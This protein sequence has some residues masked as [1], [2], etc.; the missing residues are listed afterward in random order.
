MAKK[1]ITLTIFL[2]VTRVCFGQTQLE[3][4][5][6]AY[7]DYLNA[8]ALMTK[9]YRKAQKVLA[10]SKQKKLLLDAQRAWLIFKESHCK[11]VAEA[12]DKGSMQ[13]MVYSTCLQQ[14][15]KERTKQLKR[16][17]NDEVF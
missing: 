14:I 4:N 17:I 6:K 7:D 2:F 13:P 9:M 8:D 16:I 10:N 15:T 3:M 12:Y 5:E 1:I 11:T